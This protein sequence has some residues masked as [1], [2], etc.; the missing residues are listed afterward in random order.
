VGADGAATLGAL[1]QQTVLQPVKKL[2]IIANSAIMGVSGAVGLSQRIGG[3]V[4]KLWEDRKL[5][6]ASFEVMQAIRDG[7]GPMLRAEITYAVEAAKLIGQGPAY[8]SAVSLTVLA[9]PVQGVLRLYQFGCTGDPEEATKDLPFVAIGSGQ[10]LADPFL[11]FLREIFWK[12]SQPTM[13]EGIFA[14]VWSLLHAIRRNT[15][16]V[17]EP[18]QLMTLSKDGNNYIAKELD[19]D[20]LKETRQNVAEAEEYLSKYGAQQGEPPPEP[21]APEAAV[22]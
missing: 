18:I 17:S 4:N 16:G 13:P 11:A 3:T 20:E 21:P 12:Q 10:H 7:I 5:R 14:T 1:G 6:G 19:A 8:G 22:R 15:G 2:S 9:L